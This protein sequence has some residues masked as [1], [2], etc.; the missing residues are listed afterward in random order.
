MRRAHYKS[1]VALI[2]IAALALGEAPRARAQ[3]ETPDLRMF[4]RFVRADLKIR[5]LRRLRTPSMLEQIRTLRAMGY[6]GGARQTAASS[7]A[8]AAGPPA[9]N[10]AVTPG[11][12]HD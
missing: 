11:Q 1:M 12:P 7:A 10:E 4:L 9:G 5:R 8:A 3:D 6:L 2:V